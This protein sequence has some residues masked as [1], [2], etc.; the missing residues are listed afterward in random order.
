MKAMILAAGHGKRLRPLTEAMP[1]PMI[2]IASEPL[3]VHQIRWLRHAGI[4]EIVINLHH[5]GAQIE[6]KLGR[7]ADLGVHITYCHEEELL[8][9]GGAIVKALPF[10]LPGPFMVLNGDIWTSYPFKQLVQSP[11]ETTHL[12]LTPKPNHRESG[13]F[14]LEDNLVRRSEKNDLVFCGISV[15]TEEILGHAPDDIFSIT[16]DLYFKRL[17]HD[18]ITGEIYEG[19]W[20]DIGSHDQLKAVRRLYL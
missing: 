1:K 2:P 20:F 13:D 11:P 5:L 19:T 16:Q 7:G 3:I 8:G 12:V 18:E 6:N 9:T 17:S 15:L 14:Y 4:S 10:L